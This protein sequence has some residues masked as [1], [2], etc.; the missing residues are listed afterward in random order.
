M[1]KQIKFFMAQS[2]LLLVAA[3]L[4]GIAISFINAAWSPKIEANKIAKFSKQVNLII[5]DANLTEL[6]GD[7]EISKKITTK[8]FQIADKNGNK[9]GFAFKAKGPA[10]DVIELVI[11]VNADC[12]EILGYGV[13][14]C[15]ETPGFGDAIKFDYFQDQFADIPLGKLTLTKTGDDSVK[16]TE[17]VAISGATIS[18][19]GV[20]DIFNNYVEKIKEEL[21]KRGL[22]N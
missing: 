21:I 15:N 7:F 20:I 18:S 1:L 13:L 3:L 5:A 12:S 14:V 6:E 22:V 9:A 4:F 11:A 19:Q 2:W 17:I 10:Y 8:V 16:D